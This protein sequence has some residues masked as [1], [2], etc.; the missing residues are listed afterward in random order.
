MPPDRAV[1]LSMDYYEPILQGKYDDFP[2]RERDLHQLVSMAGRYKRIRGFLDD[3]VLDPPTSLA[4]LRPKKTEDYL[5]LSTVHS[6]KGLEWQ[7]VHII[8]VM[9][10]YF[11]SSKAYSNEE[12]L[13]EERR[14][15]YVA[16]TRAKDRLV[17]YYPSRE[18]RPVWSDHGGTY[19]GYR[20]GL[21]SFIRALPH[22]VF[23]HGST[24]LFKRNRGM[25]PTYRE[26]ALETEDVCHKASL[27]PGDRVNHPAFGRGVI[28]KF[29]GKEKVE[30][31][32]RKVGK[33]LL[34]LEYTTLEKM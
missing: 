30:V 6:A 25:E 31:L 2:R 24:E 12:S 4:D 10:G 18:S 16:T 27:R 8:W 23:D 34:H 11:P 19:A 5:T 29:I 26:A 32:F 33:K 21:S 9:D 7:V 1:E 15:M 20:G 17:L 14:L 13:E 3:V 28:S 22:D